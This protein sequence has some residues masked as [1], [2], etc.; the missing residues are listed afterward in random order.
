MTKR[1]IIKSVLDG[2][3]PP[4]V[5]W[6]FKFTEEQTENTTC[7]ECGSNVCRPHIVFFGENPFNMREIERKLIECTHFIYIGTSS[8]VYPAA[9]FKTMAKQSRSKVLCI[10]LDVEEDHVTD[11]FIK[12]YAGTEVPNFVKLITGKDLWT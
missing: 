3:K 6:S 10:N 9:G 2:K 5:P 7:P 11:F 1:E 8:Q 4:Y 12:G